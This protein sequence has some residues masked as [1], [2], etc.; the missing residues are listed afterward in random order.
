MPSITYGLTVG[1]LCDLTLD[2]GSGSYTMKGVR[3]HGSHKQGGVLLFDTSDGQLIVPI[4]SVVHIL[5][6]SVREKP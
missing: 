5:N 4:S 2:K 6:R 3:F 1:D